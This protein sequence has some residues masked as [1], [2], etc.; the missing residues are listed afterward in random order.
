MRV[1][2]FA[3]ALADMGVEN[4]S[5][6]AVQLPNLPQ[7][8]IAYYAVLKPGPHPRFPQRPLYDDDELQTH[9]QGVVKLGVH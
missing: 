6:V 7:T 5:R 2:S 3:N 4:D 1:N 8:V 9:A